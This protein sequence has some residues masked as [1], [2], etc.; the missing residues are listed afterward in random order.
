M[1]FSAE[2]CDRSH[3]CYDSDLAQL[4]TLSK[5]VISIGLVS[6]RPYLILK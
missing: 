3:S 4:K 6:L 5:D 2:K 1:R